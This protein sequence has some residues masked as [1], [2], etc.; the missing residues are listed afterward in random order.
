MKFFSKPATD[1]IKKMFKEVVSKRENSNQSSDEKDLVNHL[2]KLKAN[3]KL[4]AGS[5]SG[6][7]LSGYLQLLKI[8]Q[9]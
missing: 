1:Y 8:I 5:D 9:K 3:L 2:L 6:K 4:P 7:F